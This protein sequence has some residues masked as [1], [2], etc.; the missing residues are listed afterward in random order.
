MGKFLHFALHKLRNIG[1]HLPAVVWVERD[2]G[3]VIEAGDWPTQYN[4]A[5]LGKIVSSPDAHELADEPMHR[6][7]V[8]LVDAIN[9]TV[10]PLSLCMA[11]DLFEQVPECFLGRHCCLASFRWIEV[12]LQKSQEVR[13]LSCNLPEKSSKYGASV[14]LLRVMADAKVIGEIAR[15]FG[16][17][18][19]CQIDRHH[20][21]AFARTT[22][23]PK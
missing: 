22:S 17:N 21:F 12:G 18:F 1:A 20:C 8:T 5:Q 9:E 16:G 7:F 4:Q 13:E 14:A 10:E 3:S 19:F 2:A 11:A 23:D 6:V 15:D